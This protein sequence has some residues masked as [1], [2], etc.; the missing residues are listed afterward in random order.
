MGPPNSL[1]AVWKNSSQSDSTTDFTDFIRNGRPAS[2]HEAEGSGESKREK[3]RKE[4]ETN[5]F[6]IFI[7][8]LWF[9]VFFFFLK[10]ISN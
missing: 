10:R 9:S 4:K 5:Y 3:E 1:L 7:C 8:L 2:T 6:I